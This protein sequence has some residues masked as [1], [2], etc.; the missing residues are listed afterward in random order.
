MITNF[1]SI[2]AFVF[3]RKYIFDNVHL[4]KMTQVI[5]DGAFFLDGNQRDRLHVSDALKDAFPRIKAVLGDP[6]KILMPDFAYYILQGNDLRD[7]HVAVAINQQVNDLRAANLVLMP[8][9][10]R[11]L[12]RGTDVVP[13][14]GISIGDKKYLPRSVTI[15]KAAGPGK[16]QFRIMMLGMQARKLISFDASRAANVFRSQVVPI[17]IANAPDFRESDVKYQE[18]CASYFV[19][20]PGEATTGAPPTGPAAPTVAAALKPSGKENLV[21]KR[22]LDGSN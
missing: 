13:R 4:A 15:I 1:P 22:K 7:G 12:Y 17:L 14:D 10:D 21:M 5:Q 16:Y 8:G 20:F 19:A 11:K 6:F 9:E 18:L 3:D 2:D